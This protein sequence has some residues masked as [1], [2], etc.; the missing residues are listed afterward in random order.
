[1]FHGSR[2]DRLSKG[3]PAGPCGKVLV[4]FQRSQVIHEPHL[5]EAALAELPNQLALTRILLLVGSVC[6]V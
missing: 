4:N 2:V 3:V 1:M 6:N 5:A